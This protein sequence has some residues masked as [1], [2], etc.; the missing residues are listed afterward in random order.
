VHCSLSDVLPSGCCNVDV[1][2]QAGP[3][4]QAR[5]LMQ[6]YQYKPHASISGFWYLCDS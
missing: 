4:T 3:E 2:I 1:L 6:L 5:G